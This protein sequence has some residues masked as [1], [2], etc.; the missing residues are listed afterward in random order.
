MRTNEQ[1]ATVY[2]HKDVSVKVDYFLANEDKMVCCNETAEHPTAWIHADVKVDLL[3]FTETF[4]GLDKSMDLTV[5]RL[6]I[7]DEFI[8]EIFDSEMYEAENGTVF[9]YSVI[10]AYD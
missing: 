8:G 4:E 5:C 10:L 3:T 2:E 1:V 6:Y 7:N 9:K